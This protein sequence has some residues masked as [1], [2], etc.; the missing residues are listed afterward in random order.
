MTEK[1]EISVCIPAYDMG[2]RGV[3]FLEQSLDVL[4]TQTFKQFEVVVSDQSSDTAIA[5]LCARSSLQI[6]WIDARRVPKQASANTNLAM[7]VAAGEIVKILFQDDF[8]LGDA[9]LARI[10]QAFDD[11]KVNWCL[12]GCEHTRDGE[13]LERAL[14]AS[15]GRKA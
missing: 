2:G 10:A 14:R 15:C 5:D 9:A 12:T 1:I 6:R 7:N 3:A 8:L 11:P 13:T 4:S